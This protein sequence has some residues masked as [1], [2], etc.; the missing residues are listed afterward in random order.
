LPLIPLKLRRKR[1]REIALQSLVYTLYPSDIDRFNAARRLLRM[2]PSTA[3]ASGD[4]KLTEYDAM[5]L[6]GLRAW[7]AANSGYF[8]SQLETWRFYSATQ[9]LFLHG[10]EF[11]TQTKPSTAAAAS[12]CN[13]CWVE[14][15]NI[16][17]SNP[18]LEFSNEGKS[19]KRPGSTSSYPAAFA[20]LP[21]RCV[22]YFFEF[23]NHFT[24]IFMLLLANAVCRLKL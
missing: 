21:D 24:N 9:F 14:K 5:V 15:W 20:D 12:G 4:N 6:P 16:G 23:T 11:V 7:A 2:A 18:H 13:S 19:V 3:S 10:S 1:E 17:I 8:S 22:N